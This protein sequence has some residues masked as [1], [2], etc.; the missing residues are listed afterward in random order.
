VHAYLDA[1]NAGYQRLL[2]T[3]GVEQLLA[4]VHPLV[5][6][7]PPVLEVATAGTYPDDYLHGR[8]LVLIPS[9]FCWPSP[10]I[11]HSLADQAAPFLLLV[12][13]VRDLADLAAAWTAG[14]RHGRALVALLGRSRAAVLEVVGDGCTTTE[15]AR[16][17]GVSVPS[18]SQHAQ[19]LRDSGLLVT[20]RDGSSVRHDLTGLG[21]AL[22][23]GAWPHPSRP[24]SP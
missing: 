15:L 24:R 17:A 14:E 18:A 7:R 10:I 9:L 13:A 2:A 6:W 11:L 20:R 23:D 16:R 4:G 3:G 8:G 1:A 21:V 5:R 12:P 19:V 22:L